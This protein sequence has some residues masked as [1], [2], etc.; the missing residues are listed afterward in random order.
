MTKER[1]RKATQAL[2]ESAD[3][4]LCQALRMNGGENK[5]AAEKIVDAQGMLLDAIAYLDRKQT[6]NKS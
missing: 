4:M 2:I 6:C 1:Q 3:A 5:L